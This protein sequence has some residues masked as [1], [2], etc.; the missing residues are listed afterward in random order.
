MKGTKRE[1]QGLSLRSK[2]T[3]HK[4]IGTRSRKLQQDWRCSLQE[5]SKVTFFNYTRKRR[6]AKDNAASVRNQEGKPLADGW[7]MA[8]RA[9]L[10]MLHSRTGEGRGKGRE[11]ERK[12]K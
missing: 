6:R 2:K 3:Q 9:V 10:L 8:G 11:T 4:F 1:N 5:T 7:E 12:D